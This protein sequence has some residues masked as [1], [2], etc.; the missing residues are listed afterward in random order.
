MYSGDDTYGDDITSGQTDAQRIAYTRM[1]MNEAR[2]ALHEAIRDGEPTV[3]VQRLNR[4]YAD[5]FDAFMGY[6]D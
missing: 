5:A 1:R 6:A 3:V 2:K 4:E